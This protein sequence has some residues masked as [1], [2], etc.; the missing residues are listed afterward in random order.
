MISGPG[1]LRITRQFL[2]VTLGPD[3]VFTQLLKENCTAVAYVISGDGTFDQKEGHPVQGQDTV[4]L[5]D[6]SSIHA[7][8]SEKG[9][10]FLFRSGSPICKPVAWRIPIVMNTHEDLRQAFQEYEEGTF[11]RKKA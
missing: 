8:W 6:G 4:L 3:T 5:G 2:E 11:I 9:I 10:R 7:R 1:N